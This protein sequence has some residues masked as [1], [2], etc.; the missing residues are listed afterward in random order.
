MRSIHRVLAEYTASITQAKANPN[1]LLEEAHGGAVVVMK[2]NDPCFYM[3]PQEMFEDMINTLELLQHGSTDLKI[4]EAKFR[5]TRARLE[6]ITQGCAKALRNASVNNDPG[7][8][9]C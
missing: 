6:K 4:V 1:K 5:P 3:V 9:E 7:F 2:N 8:E